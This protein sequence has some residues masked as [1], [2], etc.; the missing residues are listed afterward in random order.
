[1]SLMDIIIGIV[2]LLGFVAIALW[3]VYGDKFKLGK[4]G[5]STTGD[6]KPPAEKK[7]P[8]F[9]GGGA[10]YDNQHAN[11]TPSPIRG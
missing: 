1:M 11:R 9:S 2:V 5:D 4:K 3:G 10:P 7:E 6:S 8:V